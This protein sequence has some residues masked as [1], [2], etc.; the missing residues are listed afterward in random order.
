M[1]Q[2]A[3]GWLEFSI[4]IP[5]LSFAH[6]G[7][8]RRIAFRIGQGETTRAATNPRTAINWTYC[9]GDSLRKR[10]PPTRTKHTRMVTKGGDKRPEVPPFSHRPQGKTVSIVL[11][12]TPPAVTVIV[13][14]IV[15]AAAAVLM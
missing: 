1:S 8:P 14:G 7:L 2:L 13:T 6:T 12:L 5:K 4:A 15:V 10:R 11:W 3:P 9:R